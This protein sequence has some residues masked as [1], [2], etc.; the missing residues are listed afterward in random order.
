MLNPVTTVLG[1][2]PGS[3]LGF[4]QSHEHVY[5][6]FSHPVSV[7]QLIDDP[8][9]SLMELLAYFRAGGGAVVDAQ[10][11]GCGRNAAILSSLA[12]QSGVHIIASTGFHKLSYYPENHWIHSLSEDHLAHIFTG[13]LEQGMYLDGGAVFPQ[14]QCSARAGQIKTALDREGLT[15]RYRRLFTAAAAAAVKTG[16]PL[17]VHVEQ[18]SDPAALSDFLQDIG[19]P[20]EQIIFCHLDRAVPDRRVHREICRRGS[21]LEYD[22]IGRPKYHDDLE[23][24]TLIRGLLE[25]GY[26]TRLLLSMDTTRGRLRS[27]GGVPG[28]TYIIEQFIPQMLDWGI[29]REQ[30]EGFFVKNPARI[31]ASHSRNS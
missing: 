29:D 4:C 15:P 25:A 23:E 6:S 18:S 13:E 11:L 22:T 8:D 26:G 3:A 7:E 21:C 1:D 31:F 5:I 20:P 2:I 19:L 10:P 16:K 9:K 17:M 24:I 12:R 27:Y 14:K 28:L 30:I